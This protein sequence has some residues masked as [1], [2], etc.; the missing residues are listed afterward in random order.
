MK[1]ARS[2]NTL[3][4]SMFGISIGILILIQSGMIWVLN[5]KKQEIDQANIKWDVGTSLKSRNFNK[6]KDNEKCS[7]PHIK[8]FE[9]S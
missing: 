5:G 2:E 6:V 4:A 9:D 7:F 8:V 3:C 1:D